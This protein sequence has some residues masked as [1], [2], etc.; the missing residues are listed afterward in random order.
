MSDEEP[1]K[2]SAASRNSKWKQCWPHGT[3]SLLA[4]PSP[5]I[6]SLFT[7][8]SSLFGLVLVVRVDSLIKLPEMAKPHDGF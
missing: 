7:T 4:H 1:S 5:D 6:P 2:P 3:K 8:I